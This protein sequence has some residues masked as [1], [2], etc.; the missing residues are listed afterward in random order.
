MKNRKPVVVFALICALVLPALAASNAVAIPGTTAFTCEPVELG[1]AFSD[2]HCTNDAE[3]G[4]GFIHEILD[5]EVATEVTVTNN[6]TGK[7]TVPAKFKT[8]IAGVVVELE[9]EAFHSCEFASVV[10]LEEGGEMFAGGEYCGEFTKVVVKKPANCSVP[11]NAVKV[12]QALW[13]TKV[14]EIKPGKYEMWVKFDPEPGEPLAE[15]EIT[16]ATCAIKGV[17]VKVTGEAHANVMTEERPLDGA[18]LKFTTALT[19]GFLNV[20]A[21]KAAFEGTFTPVSVGEVKNPLTLTTT[22]N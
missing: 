3:G 15:F 12:E 21:Q 17:K 10:N 22:E 14:G 5:E 1:A 18:T 7:E 11:G 6:K 13:H 16:G 4:K 2:A 19:E 9:A 8:V 20:G